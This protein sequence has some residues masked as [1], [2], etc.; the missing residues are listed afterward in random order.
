MTRNFTVV[1]KPQ[2]KLCPEKKGNTR[3]SND[4]ITGFRA[5]KVR[6]IINM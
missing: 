4:A 5:T 2:N 3:I 6:Q 1:K